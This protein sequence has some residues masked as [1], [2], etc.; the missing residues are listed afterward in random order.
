M[1]AI[2]LLD[3]SVYLNILDVPEFNQDRVT[4]LEDFANKVAD[5]D[6]FLLPLATILET[7]NHI[8]DLHGGGNRRRFAQKL[9]DDV[10]SALTGE[11]PYRPT[12]FPKREEFLEWLGEF[13]NCAM[14]SKLS[15]RTRE[16]GVS[17]SDLSII[18]EWERMCSLNSMSR[19]L[20][21]SL[22]SDLLAHDRVP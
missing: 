19:V 20:I 6:H 14:R 2:V 17:L 18:K 3:T 22:D 5:R 11:A 10:T 1:S 9:V 15:R 16:E 12:Q 21:W 7:G 4:I 13:P 8:A